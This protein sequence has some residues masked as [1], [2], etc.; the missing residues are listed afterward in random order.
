MRDTY[1]DTSLARAD[2]GFAPTTSLTAGL[3]AEYRWLASFP[4]PA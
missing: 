4:V 2:L 1:A 3:E